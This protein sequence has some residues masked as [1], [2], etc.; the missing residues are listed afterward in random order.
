MR[1]RRKAN[2]HVTVEAMR[3]PAIDVSASDELVD[4]LDSE[5]LVTRVEYPDNGGDERIIG[6]D[7]GV[8][9]GIW[10]HAAAGDWI[11]KDANGFVNKVT[12]EEFEAEWELI[13]EG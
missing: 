1:Y 5:Q 7:I 2:H 9:P 4:F 12:H 3:L 8:R 10:A 13:N 6:V 11:T